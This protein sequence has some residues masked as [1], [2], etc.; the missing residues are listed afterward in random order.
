[1]MLRYLNVDNDGALFLAAQHVGSTMSSD[2]RRAKMI[3][4]STCTKCPYDIKN[5]V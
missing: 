5:H 3:F 2:V 4:N 1:M